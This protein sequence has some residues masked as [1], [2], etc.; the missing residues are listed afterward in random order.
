MANWIWLSQKYEYKK[1]IYAGFK[2][3]FTLNLGK[4]E[5]VSLK[6]SCD[7]LFC[8]YVNGKLAGFSGCAD[9]PHFK[10]YD[11]I[12][13][14]DLCDAENEIYVF[15]WYY[16][17]NSQTYIVSDPG[18]WFEIS[19]GDRSIC[20][21]GSD[22]LGR[23]ED[24]Y[25]H[26]RC[27]II[28]WQLGFSFAYDNTFENKNE[29]EHCICI[30]KKEPVKRMQKNLVLN[31]RAP[32]RYQDKGDRLLIDLGREVAGYPELDFESPCD[33]DLVITYGQHIETGEV[34][35]LIGGR[36]FSFEF[37]ARKGKNTWFVPLRRLSGRYMEVHYKE[38]ISP[39]YIG[40][41]EVFYPVKERKI[42]FADP[43]LQQIYDVSVRTLR[44]CMH[45]HYEDT[46]WRE[47][48]LYALDSRNQILFGYTAFEE[49]EYPRSNLALINHGLRP[50]GL[51]SIC[52]PS[53]NDYPIPFFSLAYILEVCEYVE[54]TGDRSLLDETK[55]TIS[56]I[57]ETFKSKID[58]VGLIPSFPYPFWNFYEWSEGNSGNL[59]RKA[60]DPYIKDYDLILNAFFV[61]VINIYN[62]VAGCDYDTEGIRAAI[63]NRLYD[64]EKGL[65]KISVCGNLYGQLGNS[66][67]VLAGLGDDELVEKIL[68]CKDIT[69]ATLSMKPFV[70]DAL[71]TRGDKHKQF[72][73]DDI[74]RV[75]KKMLDCGAT[76]FWE[77]EL[78]WEDFS[79]AGSLCHG[80]SASPAHYLVLLGCNKDKS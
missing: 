69:P 7:S 41:Q 48:A 68:K 47:Q 77:T 33:Q 8:A 40:L 27:Q 64:R 35:R 72:I 13:I 58:D 56:T 61:Y 6:V 49:T 45:E 73:I 10:L 28:T 65:Y 2:T 37:K 38:P 36:D 57:I 67:A 44:L 9:Y 43:L 80:W 1:D 51:L 74:K 59:S 3:N 26:E 16:G 54:F 20:S 50:D 11:E 53:G 62:R 31:G 17:E 19:E 63:H 66:L 34:S 4:K 29:Y 71:L 78:G 70:Y 76:S 42:N 15:V 79:F 12:D 18:L 25:K 32:V 23:L 52:F 39:T 30:D 24:N 60:E 21:S 14:T 5:R 55:A 75:Y 22:T 46:P